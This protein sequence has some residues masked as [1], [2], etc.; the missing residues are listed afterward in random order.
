MD[1]TNE[2]SQAA[3]YSSKP[4]TPNASNFDK[5]TTLETE[6]LNADPKSADP[7]AATAKTTYDNSEYE[8]KYT[9]SQTIPENK[10]NRSKTQETQIEN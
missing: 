4:A 9:A 1:I 8:K 7:K 5:K 10:T 3:K 6:M 2:I